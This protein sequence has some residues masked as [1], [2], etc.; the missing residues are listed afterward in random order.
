[1]PLPPEPAPPLAEVPP[2]EPVRG[3]FIPEPP[4]AM[5]NPA[6][7]AAA[8]KNVEQRRIVGILPSE[9]SNVYAAPSTLAGGR[10]SMF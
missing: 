6:V 9:T 2:V 5:A 1:M 3:T 4:Q 7:S 8:T 10:A